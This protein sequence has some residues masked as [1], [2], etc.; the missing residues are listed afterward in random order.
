MNDAEVFEQ[1]KTLVG[2]WSGV[3]DS[4]RAL[5]VNYKLVANN[6]VLVETWELAPQREAL[7]LY[8]MDAGKLIATH[9]CPIG[10]QP[11]LELK[12]TGHESYTFAFVS[13]TN[14]PNAHSARQ[15]SFELRLKSDDEFWRSETYTE[16][17][18]TNTD[19]ANYVRLR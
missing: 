6:S 7:T 18:E 1:L 8:H 2:N 14:L 3:T 16:G 13:A 9:Y 10:N 17:N 11:R 15:T 4:G 19:S 12:T 5:S